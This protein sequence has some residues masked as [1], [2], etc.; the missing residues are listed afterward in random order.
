MIFKIS[1]TK[2]IAYTVSC[3]LNWTREISQNKVSVL[4]VFIERKLT[5]FQ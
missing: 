2:N 3:A 4:E 1:E 5:I